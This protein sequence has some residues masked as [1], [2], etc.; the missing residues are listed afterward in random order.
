MSKL[1]SDIVASFTRKMPMLIQIENKIL[2]CNKAN[3]QYKFL[4]NKARYQNIV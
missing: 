1:Q 3:R 2:K 4:L